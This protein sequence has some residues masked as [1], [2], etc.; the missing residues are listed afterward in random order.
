MQSMIIIL[1]PIEAETLQV[2]LLT[3]QMLNVRT[4]ADTADIYPKIQFIPHTCQ[5]NSTKKYFKRAELAEKEE[6]EYLKRYRTNNGEDQ[7][8]VN[9]LVTDSCTSG[10]DATDDSS[11]H[12]ALPRRDVLRRLRERGEPVLLFGETELDAFRRLRRSEILEPEVNKMKNRK[13]SDK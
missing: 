3:S 6:E 1:V 2:F 7:L 9:K 5:H 10:K 8:N 4:L 12:A 13:L 11:D